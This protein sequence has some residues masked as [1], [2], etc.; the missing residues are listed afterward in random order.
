MRKWISYVSMGLLFFLINL[1]LTYFQESYWAW[2][3][4][5]G[6]AALFIVI[7]LIL[8]GVALYFRKKKETDQ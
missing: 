6:V 5:V 8:D 2:K 3:D 1:F 4:S 7:L